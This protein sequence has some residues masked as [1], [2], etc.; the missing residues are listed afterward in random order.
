V[1]LHRGCR[2][3]RSCVKR[4]ATIRTAHLAEP[5]LQPR[6]QHV[7]DRRFGYAHGWCRQEPQTIGLRWPRMAPG[8]GPFQ[9]VLLRPANAALPCRRRPGGLLLR[10]FIS[11]HV[12]RKIGER[13]WQ[14]APQHMSDLLQLLRLNPGH[15]TAIVA[16]RAP[17]RSV[18]DWSPRILVT[19]R[20]RKGV[21]LQL[22]AL[23]SCCWSRRRDCSEL[24]GTPLT[25]RGRTG[26]IFTVYAMEAPR[27]S[28][29]F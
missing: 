12:S 28:H 22:L 29:R 8:P 23:E 24:Q 26:R 6:H 19:Q 10:C 16:M 25:I 4:S 17:R 2:S 3:G 13:L 14:L 20:Y 11:D 21:E 15:V 7:C 5:R 18:V 9:H 1:G 27:P